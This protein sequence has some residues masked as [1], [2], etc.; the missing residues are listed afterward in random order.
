MA[1]KIK[2]IDNRFSI[3]SGGGYVHSYTNNEY[4]YAFHSV[5]TPHGFVC[6]Y[7]Q[8]DSPAAQDSYTVFRFIRCGYEYTRFYN[9]RYTR[10]GI[11]R[12]ARKFAQEIVG[13]R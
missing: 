8:G 4:N 5:T 12:L 2:K 10:L 13:R 3:K 6:V 7:T 1:K 9:Y 11:A